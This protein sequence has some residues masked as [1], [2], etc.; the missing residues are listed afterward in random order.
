MAGKPGRQGRKQL[1]TAIKLLRGTA[2]KDRLNPDEPKPS[3]ANRMPRA[4]KHLEGEAKAEWYKMGR[5]LRKLGL[6]TDIDE[7]ALAMYCQNW[8][9]WLDAEANIKMYGTFI[10]KNGVPVQ[11]PF[12]G[13]AQKAMD[14]MRSLL[15]EFGM[16]PA[17]RGRV[18]AIQPSKEEDDFGEFERNRRA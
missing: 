8:S 9:R 17:S 4:P 3:P 7:T 18:K 11:T 15:V 16:T 14:T 1:P 5:R 2:R 6:L 10:I 13:I 12:L